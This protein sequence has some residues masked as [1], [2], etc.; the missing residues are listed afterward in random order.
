MFRVT[1]KI[2][3]LQRKDCGGCVTDFYWQGT[4]R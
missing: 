4:V 3:R 1:D 2:N